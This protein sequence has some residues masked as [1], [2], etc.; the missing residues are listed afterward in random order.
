MRVGAHDLP[1]QMR[2]SACKDQRDLPWGSYGAAKKELLQIL[3]W[4]AVRNPSL[5]SPGSKALP[6][7]TQHDY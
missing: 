6:G 4:V 3:N 5:L 2:G 1:P 7:P